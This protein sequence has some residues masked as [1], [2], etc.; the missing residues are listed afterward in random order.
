MPTP[1]SLPPF[2][3]AAV[4][5]DAD[6]RDRDHDQNDQHQRAGPRQT[7]PLVVGRDGV[8]VD[9]QRQRGDG[10]VEFEAP[11]LVAEG[12]EE[13][14]R[15][16]SGD[17]GEGQHAAGDDA[18]RCG[19]QADGEHGAPLGTPRP[20]AASRMACGTVASISSVVRVMVGT[21]MMASATP[22]ASAEKCFC[23]HDDERVDGDAHHDGGNAVQHVGGK[24]DSVGE[25]GAAAELGEVDAS[26]D[27]ERNTHEAGKASRMMP[28][29]T[30]ALAMPPPASPTGAGIWV[31]KARLSELAPL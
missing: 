13:Q 24:A 6:Q 15:G 11:E 1:T 4:G 9:L 21:I 19:A 14:R 3:H 22:P 5:T 2:K 28:E 18:G 23:W 30:M 7:V 25:H 17:A 8:D 16:L 26:G 12:G 29:P 31:K 20:S 27:A 10:L